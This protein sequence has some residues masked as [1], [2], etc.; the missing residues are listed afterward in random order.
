VIGPEGGAWSEGAAG[1]DILV[2]SSSGGFAI[3]HGFGSR[4]TTRLRHEPD[5]RHMIKLAII[6]PLLYEALL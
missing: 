1:V 6:V 5:V 2:M 4:Q 3:S